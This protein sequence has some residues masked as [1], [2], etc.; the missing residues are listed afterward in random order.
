[1]SDL[2]HQENKG[3]EIQEVLGEG[4]FGA[5]YRAYQ[6]LVKRE[7]AIKVILPEYANKPDFIRSF[8]T[9]AQLIARLEHL[10]IVPLYDYW[11]DPSGAF[12]VM[13]MLRGGSLAD[14][15]RRDGP[16]SLEATA[17]LLDQ[18]ASALSVAHQSRVIHRDL[19][20]G[21]ILLDNDRNAYLSDFGLSIEL[22]G[23]ELGEDLGVMVGTPAYVAPEQIQGLEV[24]PQTDIYSLALIIWEVLTG[25]QAVQGANASDLII[26]QMSENIPLLSMYRNDLPRDLDTVF[27]I[28][29][30]KDPAKR[31]PNILAFAAAFQYALKGKQTDTSSITRDFDKYLVIPPDLQP[32]TITPEMLDMEAPGIELVNPF[33]GLRAF[34]EGDAGDFFGRE[35]LIELLLE[36][37]QQDVPNHRFLAVVGPS[38]SGKSSVVKAGVIPAIRKG[39]LPNSEHFFVVEMVPSTDALRE[40]E[41]ALL[42]IAAHPSEDLHERLQSRTEGLHEVLGEILPDDSSELFLMIDQFEEVFTQ[43]EDNAIRAHFMD[44]LQYAVMHPQSRLRVV[45]T[46]RADFFDKPLMYAEFGQLVRERFEVVLPLNNEELES[47]IVGPLRRVGARAEDELVIRIVDDVSH[48]PG[49]LPLLQYTLTELFERR[50]GLLL[51]LAAYE[52]S[53]GVLGSLARRAEELYVEMQPDQQEAVRQ[54]FLRLVTLGEGTE[55]TR[56]RILW[57]ELVFQRE[58][59]DPL[60]TVLDRF[61][62]FRLLTFDND[63]NTREPT[64]EVAHEALIRRWERLRDWL[65]TSRE[66]LRTQRRLSASVQEWRNSGGDVSFLASGVRLDQFE[67]LMKSRDIALTGDEQAYIEASI[68]KREEQRL[69]ELARQER[70]RRLEQRAKRFLQGLVAVMTIATIGAAA[71]AGYALVQRAEAVKARDRAQRQADVNLSLNLA[72]QSRQFPRDGE[73]P[74]DAISLAM[75]SVRLDNPP[76][77]VQRGLG[78]TVLQPGALRRYRGFEAPLWKATYSPDG[79]YIVAGGFQNFMIKWDAQTGQEVC[80]FPAI[81]SWVFWMAFSPDGK[82]IVTGSQKDII[83][84]W[85]AETCTLIRQIGA[86]RAGH[87]DAVFSV[88][89]SP[90]GKTILA[91]SNDEASDSNLILWDAETGEII[92]RFEGHDKAVISV[93]ISPDGTMAASASYDQ[94]V[95]LWDIQTGQEI[96][97]LNGHTDGVEAVAFSPDGT[98]LVSAGLDKFIRVW[99]VETG[100]QIYSR[101]VPDRPRG[102]DWD[103]TGRLIAAGLWAA[104]SVY[105]W[106]A[107]TGDLLH[108]FEGHGDIV[109][110]VSFSPDG[111]RLVSSAVVSAADDGVVEWDLYGYGVELARFG[112]ESSERLY[113]AAI[114][115]DETSILTGS[116]RGNLLLRNLETGEI[117]RQFSAGEAAINSLAFSPDGQTVVTGSQDNAVILWNVATGE[118]SGRLEGHLA[119][120]R[121]VVYSPDGTLIASGGGNI[122]ISEDR[123][124]DNEIILWNAADGSLLRRLSGHTASVRGLA[125]SPDGKWLVSG[126]DDGKVILWDVLTGTALHT[127]IGHGDAV[128]TVAFSHNGTRVLSGSRDHTLILWNAD[129]GA[130]I[131]R[132]RG[133]DTSVRSV[134]FS[135]DDTHALSGSGNIFD[136]AR[137]VDNS[138]ILW[139]LSSGEEIRRFNGH[140][141]P[142]RKVLYSRDGSWAVSAGDDNLLIKWR[143]HT[144]SEFIDWIY[145]GYEVVCPPPTAFGVN[146]RC[147]NIAVAAEAGEEQAPAAATVVTAQEEVAAEAGATCLVDN[148]TPLATD[149]VDTSAF[150][151]AGAVTIGYS[152]GSLGTGRDGLIAA[153]ARYEASL[154]EDVELTVSD[155]GGSYD[156]QV[157]DVTA[158]IEAEVDALIINPIEQPDMSALQTA[159]A[160]AAE[161]GIPVI[162]VNHRLAT[163]GVVS[164]VGPDDFKVGC[165][166]M[167]EIIAELDGEGNLIWLNGVDA[168]NSDND[169]KAGA[170]AVYG[171]YSTMSYAIQEPTQLDAATAQRL[172]GRAL[173]NNPNIS[174]IWTYNGC[175]S[176]TAAQSLLDAGQP[177]VPVVGDNTIGLAQ[178]MVQ[179]NLK[180]AQVRIP[181]STMGKQVIQTTLQVLA[182]EPVP[183][184]VEIPLEVI[185]AEALVE[186]D[187]N[188]PADGLVGD[189]ADLPEEFMPIPTEEG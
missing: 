95:A 183:A 38:G 148:P 166:M 84:L 138:L 50:Q 82:R 170:Q 2:L 22:T 75:E 158:L 119:P 66:D 126:G 117:I 124:V 12:L 151:E 177:L 103:P 85:D 37:L 70:E 100:T 9:E 131:S 96:R 39:A 23:D 114:S 179:N 78:E 164:F 34:Q 152:S 71:L 115:P 18:I 43:T 189:Y 149:E 133:H 121:S 56:R 172:V 51:T 47:T 180:G 155:A 168:T 181:A 31:Y 143:I 106:D 35:T 109:T 134:V 25:Q 144:L 104:S 176:L 165:V 147:L 33:K 14:S 113:A 110:G 137:P 7:V 76:A 135:P 54:L 102:A 120:V 122:Q 42:G 36:R 97:R 21:N 123:P 64:V 4:G 32:F 157:A 101:A 112:G 111:R 20:P 30:A 116:D 29:T 10:H 99:D 159:I 184:F 174:G 44:M 89:F 8:E 45:I 65:T 16:W 24:T 86:G 188:H 91:G 79:R 108:T 15:L 156:Q 49:A 173:T 57:S 17:R 182:G 13:R 146:P 132:L 61:G 175:L 98:Q 69:A 178:F 1:M 129:T 92:R 48:E 105:V 130:L 74:F 107:N 154:H 11:R 83:H 136:P 55:D 87:K 160:S 125:F 93:D 118:E 163:E 26:K 28:A 3:Y 167:Q 27:Q 40:L 72:Q 68:A 62:R 186:A 77:E 6:P 5:V 187:L 88:V 141:A 52:E 145:A 81:N 185:Q 19:K 46:I 169:R 63:P 153:W 58:E 73:K 94:T 59:D 171:L 67:A 41:A 139:D 161:K 60:Q 142:I 80:R 140:G 127:M 162:L 90:D 150:A 53:G 128:L